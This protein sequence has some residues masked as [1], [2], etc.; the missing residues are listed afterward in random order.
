MPDQSQCPISPHSPFLL[1]TLQ[2]TLLSVC[3]PFF[4]PL[5]S[6]DS[7][8]IKFYCNK[9]WQWLFHF[10]PSMHCCFSWHTLLNV[11]FSMDCCSPAMCW[12][13]T[14]LKDF[15]QQLPAGGVLSYHCFHGSLGKMPG[16]DNAIGYKLIPMSGGR[17]GAAQD[18]LWQLDQKLR[19]PLLWIGP[20]SVVQWHSL[21]KSTPAAVKCNIT[22]PS[23]QAASAE[24]QRL[25]RKTEFKS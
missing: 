2:Y 14:L 3:L 13:R 19:G 23:S 7:Y 11:A 1:P 25:N 8:M 18:K 12:F 24:P 10:S 6:L 9:S 17:R 4:Q 22:P 21:F 5:Y 15:V 16:S 20:P